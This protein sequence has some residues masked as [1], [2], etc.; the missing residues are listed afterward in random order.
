MNT[1]RPT[2]VY[3][4]STPAI[5]LNLIKHHPSWIVHHGMRII[6]KVENNR[7]TYMHVYTWSLS[8]LLSAQAIQ[9]IRCL[10]EQ[11]FCTAFRMA[12]SEA[13]AFFAM[14]KFIWTLCG[15]RNKL[16]CVGTLNFSNWIC[17]LIQLIHCDDDWGDLETQRLL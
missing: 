6:M 10:S 17:V 14:W 13:F 1:L 3:N 8:L 11:F 7:I 15:L 9:T 4:S 12:Y 16:R 5:S 2:L